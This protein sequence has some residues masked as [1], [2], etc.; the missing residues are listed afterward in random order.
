[1]KQ[2]NIIPFDVIRYNLAKFTD[3]KLGQ[4]IFER[5]TPVMSTEEYHFRMKH[6][7]IFW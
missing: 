7:R 4:Y 6:P 5:D 3:K 1:M 2:K